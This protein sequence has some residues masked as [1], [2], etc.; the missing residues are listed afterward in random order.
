MPVLSNK[1]DSFITFGWGRSRGKQNQKTIAKKCPDHFFHVLSKK[2]LSENKIKQK[3][4]LVLLSCI[5]DALT[6]QL[7]LHIKDGLFCCRHRWRS[8]NMYQIRSRFISSHNTVKSIK[9]TSALLYSPRDVIELGGDAW[10]GSQGRMWLLIKQ[11]QR[12]LELW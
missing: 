3:R 8:L 9:L 10:D 6:N 11:L 7:H 2:I 5:H 1:P 12:N 4:I